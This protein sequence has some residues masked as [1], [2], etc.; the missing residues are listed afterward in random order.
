MK[1][2]IM[3]FI[4]NASR[5]QVQNFNQRLGGMGEWRVGQGDEYLCKILC[6]VYI[7]CLV[8]AN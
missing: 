7:A 4:Y 1:L 5:F 3:S 6:L 8:Y 2:K